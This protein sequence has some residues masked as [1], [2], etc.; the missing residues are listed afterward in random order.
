MRR[1]QI[2]SNRGRIVASKWFSY[3]R[4][5][6]SFFLYRLVHPR[7]THATFLILADVISLLVVI[8]LARV[9]KESL[10]SLWVG[11]LA[12]IQES[13]QVIEAFGSTLCLVIF[14]CRILICPCDLVRPLQFS[15]STYAFLRWRIARVR[16]KSK[17]FDWKTKVSKPP[18]CRQRSVRGNS[19][20]TV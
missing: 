6:L 14:V 9:F 1:C 19:L 13:Y 15:L 10:S 17:P 12:P 7:E 3:I 11:T 8:P 4:L 16:A 20:R 2:S 5:S 18:L